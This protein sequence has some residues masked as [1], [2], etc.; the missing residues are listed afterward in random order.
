M[1]EEGVRKCERGMCEKQ[2]GCVCVCVCVCVSN[3][4]GVAMHTQKTKHSTIGLL[5]CVPPK[6]ADK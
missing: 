3:G 5:S 6:H 2:G 1:K 4:R